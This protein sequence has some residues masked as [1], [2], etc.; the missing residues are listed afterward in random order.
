VERHFLFFL[1]NYENWSDW[2]QTSASKL[3]CVS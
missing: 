3:Y 1:E 2:I